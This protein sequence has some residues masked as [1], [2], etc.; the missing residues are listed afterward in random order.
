MTIL[1]K[2]R[3]RSLFLVLVIAIALFAFVL[4]PS[5]ISSFFDSNNTNEIA[6]VDGEAVSRDEFVR[7]LENYKAQT[8]G[9]V[10]ELQA[11]KAV[12]EGM[13]SQ[14]VYENQLK[15]VGIS[16]GEGDIMN[17]LYE[18]PSINSDKRFQSAGIFDKEKFKKYLAEVKA[19]NGEEWRGWQNY[20]LSLEQSIARNDYTNLVSASLNTTQKEGELAYL[21]GGVKV[22]ADYVYVPY[23]SVEDKLVNI[24]KKDVENYINNHKNDFQ[25]DASRDIEYVKFDIKAS[26]EDEKAIKSELAGL[27]K[28]KE[29]YSS[30]TK[31]NVL[32]RGLK[33][34]TDYK[35]FLQ[36]NNS[37]LPLDESVKFKGEVAQEIEKDVFK[38]KKGDVFGPYKDKGY[39]KVTKISEVLKLPDSVEA[40]HILIPY[41]GSLRASAD[42]TRGKDEAKKLADSLLVVV[43]KNAS[44]FAGLAKEFSS[45]KGSSD[46]G[47][48]YDWFG[49]NMMTPNFRDFCFES[50]KGEMGVV[51]TPFGFHIIKVEGQKNFQPVVK[52]V[53]FARKIEASEVTENSIY[54]N[55][56]SFALELS[57]GKKFDELVKEKGLSSLPVQGLK[58]LDDNVPGLGSERQIVL[59]A[60][61]K[62][63]KIGSVKRF[64]VNGGYV[65]AMLTN[66][67]EKGLMPVEKAM[68]KVKPI[69]VNEKKASI[70]EGKMNGA[71]LQEIAK[72]SNVSVRGVS[73][74]NLQSPVISGVGSEPK[75][76]G[77]MINS[78]KDKLVNKVVGDKGVFA[79]KVKEKTA[80][81]SLETYNAYKLRLE[82]QRKN[83]L[84]KLGDAIKDASKVESNI[85]FFYGVQ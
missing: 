3:E 49:Y 19:K 15:K 67:V 9:R 51:E 18:N 20:M 1:S 72:A 63:N 71:N 76:V 17:A 44:K 40:R 21:E 6:N 75:V 58:S 31:G 16:V 22:D 25:V 2:I 47:G 50:K 8:G 54:Q 23:T 13:V 38:G 80:P 64:D 53:T 77:A 4:D 33:N 7:N 59:W 74:V 32:V 84:Y 52:L 60:F 62:D 69:L 10:S 28:D 83:Q 55:S 56:E 27:L 70:I 57:K 68:A 39:Y 85:D 12:Y 61:E 66:K 24:S 65:V 73:G 45:D 35:K 43:K 48:K 36:E 14:K 29:V 34:T 82:N 46:K 81:V 42:V 37:D 78:Q 5:T 79:F 26:V 41:T 30:A 11:V